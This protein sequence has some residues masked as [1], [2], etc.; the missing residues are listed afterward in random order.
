MNVVLALSLRQSGSIQTDG[1]G[2]RRLL[3]LAP[4]EVREV[5]TRRH[6]RAGKLV[7]LGD[8][9]P[10]AMRAAQKPFDRD[11]EQPFAELGGTGDRRQH[12]RKHRNTGCLE[13]LADSLKRAMM[14]ALI[15]R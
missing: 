4:Q 14:A 11:L 12:T 13:E 2:T 6:R 7:G 8:R 5:L 10:Q 15:G 9:C 1:E 3:F